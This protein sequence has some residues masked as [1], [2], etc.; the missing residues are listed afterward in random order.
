MVSLKKSL[1][2]NKEFSDKEVQL[3]EIQELDDQL[4]CKNRTS[5][6]DL[7]EA[8]FEYFELERVG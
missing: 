3:F 8:F 6:V 2:A 5:D 1:T 7:P 4:D